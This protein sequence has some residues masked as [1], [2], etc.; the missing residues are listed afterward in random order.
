M[1]A[2]LTRPDIA[3]DWEAGPYDDFGIA[4]GRAEAASAQSPFAGDTTIRSGE[5]IIDTAKRTVASAGARVDLTAREFDLLVH[6]ASHPGRVYRRAELLDLVWGY[7]FDG[8][9]HT[10]AIILLTPRGGAPTRG[11][12]VR[13]AGAITMRTTRRLPSEAVMEMTEPQF[14]EYVKIRSM[15]IARALSAQKYGTANRLSATLAAEK[16]GR[17]SFTERAQKAPPAPNSGG[18][19]VLSTAGTG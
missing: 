18:E 15:L 13:S 4:L 14:E 3:S 10:V 7:G 5:L 16:L 9:E 1:A 11:C 19:V 8:Y 17:Y 2:T 12:L 6:L